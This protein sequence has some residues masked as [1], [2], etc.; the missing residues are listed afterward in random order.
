MS[1]IMRTSDIYFANFY[2]NLN[3]T[4]DNLENNNKKNF[5]FQ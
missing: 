2:L 5:K 3:R 1:I 4:K